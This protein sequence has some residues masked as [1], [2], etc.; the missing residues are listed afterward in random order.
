MKMSKSDFDDLIELQRQVYSIRTID[1]DQSEFESFINESPFKTDK[2]LA[3][4]LLT[5]LNIFVSTHPK[6]FEYVRNFIIESLLDTIDLFFPGELI[7]IFD[8]FGI[9]LALYENKKVSI[10]DI[11]EYSINN[12]TMFFYFMNEIKNSDESF[13]EQFLMKNS[14][15]ASQLKNID[16]EKHCRLRKAAVNEHP[17]ASAIR[18]D[19]INSFQNIIAETNRSFNSRIPFSYYELCKYINTKDSMPF[20]IDYA[21]FYG[22]LEIFKFFWVNGTDPSPKLPLFAFAGG[23]YEIIHLIESNPKMKFDTTC[24]QVAIEFHRNDLLQ[25]LEENYNMKHSSDNILR[26]I[27]FYNIDIFVEL[28]PFMMEKIKMKTDFVYDNILC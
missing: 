26:A 13:Y 10:D 21:A 9:L 14:G 7:Q 20:L 2:I 24:F 3:I 5:T 19:D 27:N 12:V 1:F 4:E 18:N 8:N 17:I 11:I 25:Y 23:N 22:S 16:L 28:L 6:S 15:I